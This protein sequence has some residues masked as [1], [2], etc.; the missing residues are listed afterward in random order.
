MTIMVVLMRLTP[1]RRPCGS[2]SNGKASCCM[3]QCTSENMPRIAHLCCV[4][5]P[6]WCQTHRCFVNT[7][8]F[9]S[10]RGAD[11]R[12]QSRSR[13]R[14]E[15]HARP[16]S[17]THAQTES[18]ALVACCGGSIHGTQAGRSSQV[19]RAA[20]AMQKNHN[21]AI[22]HHTHPKKN[23]ACGAR[24]RGRLRRECV[25]RHTRHTPAHGYPQT[26]KKPRVLGLARVPL[27]RGRENR[28]P[29]GVWCMVFWRGRVRTHAPSLCL[30][31]SVRWGPGRL[32]AFFV[33]R[34][35]PPVLLDYIATQ[36]LPAHCALRGCVR[37]LFAKQSSTNQTQEKHR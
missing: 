6:G 3:V 37:F 12:V 18:W 1:P 10:R 2:R 20:E 32:A 33:V 26:S 34:S 13:L 11:C 9:Y 30:S 17:S 16:P 19:R 36:P 15:E 22:K 29:T 31:R 27:G 28:E 23:R 21:F 7:P 5:R 35:R 8:P 24:L 14:R 4:E 25:V